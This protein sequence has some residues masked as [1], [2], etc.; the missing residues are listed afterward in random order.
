MGSFGS[1]I[2]PLRN[3]GIKIPAEYARCEFLCY[4]EASDIFKRSSA[5]LTIPKSTLAA[6]TRLDANKTTRHPPAVSAIILQ[7]LY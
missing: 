7:T 6:F 4:K 1:F 5:Q 2:S 3:E